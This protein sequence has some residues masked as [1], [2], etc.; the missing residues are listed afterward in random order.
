MVMI[1]LNNSRNIWSIARGYMHPEMLPIR[2]TS[3][4]GTNFLM[5]SIN[6]E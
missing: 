6:E 5:V 1:T 4:S 3:L 2:D